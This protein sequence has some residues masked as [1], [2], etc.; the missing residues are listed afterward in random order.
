MQRTKLESSSPF[1]SIIEALVLSDRAHKGQSK[2]EELVKLFCDVG[3]DVFA[4][5]IEK[6][7]ELFA[8]GHSNLG[9]EGEESTGQSL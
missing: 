4:K 1:Q 5:G 6:V 2:G 8:K 3:C 9:I 7:I